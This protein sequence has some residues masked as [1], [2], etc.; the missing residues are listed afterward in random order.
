MM[1]RETLYYNG[2]NRNKDRKGGKERFCI[3][4]FCVMGRA[5]QGMAGSLMELLDTVREKHFVLS[6]KYGFQAYLSS[7]LN[8]SP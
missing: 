5:T 3:H 2:L 4:V 8:F 1:E 7:S 6:R